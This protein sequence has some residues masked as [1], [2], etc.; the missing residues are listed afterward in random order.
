MSFIIANLHYLCN[1]P[2]KYFNNWGNN[3][4]EN[5]I[6]VILPLQIEYL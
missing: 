5:F 6:S 3:L 4:L 2:N 1:F